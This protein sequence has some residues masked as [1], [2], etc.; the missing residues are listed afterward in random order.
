MAAKPI[1]RKQIEFEGTTSQVVLGDGT[2]GPLPGGGGGKSQTF[3]ATASQTVFTLPEAAVAPFAMY[4]NGVE[5]TTDFAYFVVSTTTFSNDT[6][7]WQD[8][9]FTMQAGFEVVARYS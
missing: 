2:L 1:R 4:V 8:K 5:Y 9:L 6:W 7:T 3:T